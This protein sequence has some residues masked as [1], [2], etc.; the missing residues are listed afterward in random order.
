MKRFFF[1]LL[2][3]LPVTTVAGGLEGRALKSQLATLMTDYRHSDGVEVVRLGR[4]A[5]GAVKGVVRI[6]AITDSDVREVREL[7]KGVKSLY[8]FDY[9]SCK[10]DL[11][12]KISRRLNGIFRNTELLMEVNDSDDQMRLYGLYDER[13]ET[14]RDFVLYTPS[15]CT[16]VCLFGSVSMNTL[17]RMMADD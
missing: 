8:V 17:A 7:I 2:L 6:A 12:D 5:T 1:F 3:L 14:V 10:P 15:E 13:T 9:G 4:L 11:R 16:L